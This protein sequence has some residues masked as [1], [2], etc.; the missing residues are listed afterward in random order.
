MKNIYLFFFI[1]IIFLSL[2]KISYSAELPSWI[3]TP[4]AEGYRICAAGTALKNDNKALQKKIARMNAMA[5]LSKINEV[6]VANQLDIET[7]TTTYNGSV[8]DNS[9]NI[10]SKSRQSSNSVIDN[11]EEV[12]NFYDEEQGIYYILLCTK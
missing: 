11:A 3:L 9:R 1:N 5:E 7:K 2:V 6:K 8:L 10:S 4:A 12:D